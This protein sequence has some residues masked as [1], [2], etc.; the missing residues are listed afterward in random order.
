MIYGSTKSVSDK[1][2]SFTRGKL[3]ASAGEMLPIGDD[4]Q[5]FAGDIRATENMGLTTLQTLF[6]R[7]HN[8]LCDTIY[9]ANKTLT[10]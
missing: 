2:R 10:D 5:Y 9:E 1:L 6:L 3:R 4:G 8:R 7:E